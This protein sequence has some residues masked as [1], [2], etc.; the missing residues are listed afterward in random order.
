MFFKVGYTRFC[1]IIKIKIFD[2]I[3]KTKKYFYHYSITYKIM[4]LLK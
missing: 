3:T 2:T 1:L 4:K